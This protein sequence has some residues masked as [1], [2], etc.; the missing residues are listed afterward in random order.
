[1]DLATS[2]LVTAENSEHPRKIA[3]IVPIA[4]DKGEASV[5][6]EPRIAKRRAELVKLTLEPSSVAGSFCASMQFAK[7]CLGGHQ[8][9]IGK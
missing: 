3:K 7:G 6:L 2:F 8:S 9:G 5:L 4:D 1:V